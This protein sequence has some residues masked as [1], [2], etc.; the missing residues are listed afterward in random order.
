ML[1]LKPYFCSTDMQWLMNI[2]YKAVKE[3]EMFQHNNL[4]K[5]CQ[6]VDVGIWGVMS[7]LMME[8][9]MVIIPA[10]PMIMPHRPNL[11]GMEMMSMTKKRTRRGDYCML[12]EPS[13]GRLGWLI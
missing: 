3:K 12:L 4:R 2:S 8:M 1:F 11:R 13:L 6:V 9:M 7:L 5:D 10:S